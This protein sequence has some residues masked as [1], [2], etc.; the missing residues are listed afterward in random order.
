MD[1]DLEPIDT[2]RPMRQMPLQPAFDRQLDL[3]KPEV[4]GEAEPV[5]F[6]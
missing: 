6:G 3:T 2:R 5:L 1:V 4:A